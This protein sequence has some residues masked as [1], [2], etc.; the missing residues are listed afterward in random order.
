MR[1]SPPGSNQRHIDYV[2]RKERQ[3]HLPMAFVRH[4]VHRADHA[5]PVMNAVATLPIVLPDGTNIYPDL[6]SIPIAALYFA[7]LPSWILPE[8]LQYPP[9]H[10]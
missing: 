7:C 9:A 4:F 1:R 2:N 10:R 8:F 5:L 6:D 3:V